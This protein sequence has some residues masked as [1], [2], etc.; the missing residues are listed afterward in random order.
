MKSVIALVAVAGMTAVASAAPVTGTFR[1]EVSTDGGATWGSAKTVTEGNSF[2]VRGMAAWT[3]DATASIGFAGA[4]FDE[5][6][7]LGATQAEAS[8]FASHF[9]RQ[10]VAETWALSDI[11]G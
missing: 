6:D 4:T 8:G 7:L 2:K 11:T 5:I 10:G 1:W 3:D 9:K